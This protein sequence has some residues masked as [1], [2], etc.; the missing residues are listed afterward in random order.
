SVA[1]EAPVPAID[2]S[3]NAKRAAVVIGTSS[4]QCGSRRPP[5]TRLFPRRRASEVHPFAPRDPRARPLPLPSLFHA[6]P[7]PPCQL[8]PSPLPPPAQRPQ[9]PLLTTAPSRHR[10][11]V[12]HLQL[13][14]ILQPLPTSA[15]AMPIPLQHR[16]SHLRLE[17][18]RHLPAPA[19][20]QLLPR[21]LPT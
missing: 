21:H 3:A 9:I 4:P 14:A 10:H 8:P 11:D 2:T 17:R 13:H 15:A 6:A 7:P 12:V 16:P 5:G 19:A 18:P 20:Q 1:A